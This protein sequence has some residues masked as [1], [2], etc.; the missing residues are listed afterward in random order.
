VRE[1]ITTHINA[2]FDCL[3]AMIAAKRLYPNASM[4]FPGAQEK[5]LR[6]FFVHSTAYAF[7]FKRIKEIDLNKIERLILVDVRH[8][9]RIGPF[10]EVVARSDVSLHIYDHHPDETADLKGELEVLRPVG[11]TVTLFC[12][13]F[14]ERAIEPTPEEATMMMLGLYEDTGNLLFSSTTVDDFH[15][16]AF[17]YRHGADLDA[18]A[19]FLT[20]ELTAE[21]VALLHDLLSNRK[22]ISIRGHVV[23]VAHASSERQ[24]G[25]LAVLAHKLRDM[26][27][28]DALIIAV[29][30]GD[31]VFLIGRSRLP[32]V[33]VGRILAEF[34]GGGHSFAASATVRDQTLVQVLDKLGWVLDAQV[35]PHWR[36]GHLMSQPVKAIPAESDIETARQQFLRYQVNAMPVLEGAHVVGVITR[37]MVDRATHHNLNQHRVSEFMDADYPVVTPETPLLELQQ[38]ILDAHFRFLPVVGEDGRPVGAL[39]RTDLL[40]HLL[41]SHDGD[42]EPPAQRIAAGSWVKKKRMF[43]LM[44]ERLPEEIFDLLQ[45]AGAVADEL[46]ISVFIVG[47]FVRDLLL[48]KENFDLD[49]VVEGG[50]IAF[51]RALSARLDGRVRSHQ[52][53]ETAVVVCPDGRKIDIASA[54]IEFYSEP[55]ALPTIEHASIKNDLSRRDFTINTLAIA[56]N[57]DSFGLLLDFFGAQRDLKDRAIRVLHNLSFIED[58]TRVFRAVR[59]EMRLGFHL[60]RATERLL[61][62]SVRDAFVD[63]VSGPRLGNELRLILEEADAIAAVRRLE[64]LDLLSC[65]HPKLEIDARVEAGMAGAVE[66]LNWFG[67]LYTGEHINK[68]L[69]FLLALTV[70]LPAGD[71]QPLARRLGLAHRHQEIIF[72][73]VPACR[74]VFQRL[75]RWLK[76]KRKPS[77][78]EVVHLLEPF[79]LEILLL[80]LGQAKEEQVR[81]WLTDFISR[82]RHVRPELGGND[83]IRLG[84]QPGPDFKEKLEALRD[85]R[86]NGKVVTRKDEMTW[87][88]KRYLR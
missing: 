79:N 81:R 2:D 55:A 46:Q 33:H 60:G 1:V 13:I 19:D 52:K 86:L 41:S 37:Q 17:L 42:P 22:E 68:W 72:D 9:K 82:L 3:G 20:Q 4:V 76:R 23:V 77:N 18:V 49:L 75:H 21:Q 67:L 65:I 24:V 6:E 84:L 51:A 15:A 32:E 61:R 40:R 31:R 70:K 34:G 69:V 36:A 85:A 62:N 29:R 26:E 83:L 16:G 58:P 5:N 27:E 57:Q 11:S 7:D 74:N 54:R 71:L 39:T 45:T 73:Q 64:T 25:D 87:L 47:G 53:F 63:R 10:A 80:M 48:R 14:Q 38:M 59:F 12:Q 50:G 66:A 44:R 78:S 56:L 35:Q 28:L 88:R 8:S 43:S 30:T